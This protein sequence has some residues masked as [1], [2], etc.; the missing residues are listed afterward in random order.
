MASFFGH[1]AVAT[2]LSCGIKSPYKT[3]KIILF[4][5]VCAVLPD[6]DV[7]AFQ[8]GIP[9]GH[10]FGH[11]GFTHSIFFAAI[12]AFVVTLLFFRKHPLLVVYFFLSTLS[13]AVLDA[14]TNGGLGV[15]FL[16]PFENSRYFFPWQPIQVSPIGIGRFFSARGMAVIMSELKWILLPSVIWYLTIY[17]YKKRIR[18]N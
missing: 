5:I 17:I 6:A 18:G 12:L 13:H 8:F 15:A 9:Y 3:G 16:A 4:G 1:A 10:L 2:A 7:L 14:L 11:R